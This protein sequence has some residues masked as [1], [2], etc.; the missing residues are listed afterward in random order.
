MGPPLPTD[1]LATALC[2][3][4]QRAGCLMSQDISVSER[5][6]FYMSTDWLRLFDNGPDL[7]RGPLSGV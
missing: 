4:R 5:N 2:R 1:L 3:G 7:G 6:Q